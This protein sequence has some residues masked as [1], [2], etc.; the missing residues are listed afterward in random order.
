[1]SNSEIDFESTYYRYVDMI[2]RLCF[3]FLKNKEDTEEAV[4]SVL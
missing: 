3:S 2:Y 1:M 4:Q